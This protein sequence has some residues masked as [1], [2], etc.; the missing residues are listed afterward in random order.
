MND[1][2]QDTRNS[3]ANLEKEEEISEEELEAIAKTIYERLEQEWDNRAEHFHG[4]SIDT[5]PWANLPRK[6]NSV[7]VGME[8]S[9]LNSDTQELRMNLSRSV[10]NIENQLDLLTEEIYY[11]LR[12][13][14]EREKERCGSHATY[15][16]Y[17]NFW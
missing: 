5:P 2:K 9:F 3:E 14:L 15:W 8:I 17:Q 7:G 1:K 4:F 13:R 16:H 12:N 6:S 11:M 10:N